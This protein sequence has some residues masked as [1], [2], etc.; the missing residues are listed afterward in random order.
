MKSIK[1]Q[2]AEASPWAKNF[3]RDYV[4]MCHD[5]NKMIGNGK[6]TINYPKS[7]NTIII[8]LEHAIWSGCNEVYAYTN[9]GKKW[10]VG[11]AFFDEIRK[12]KETNSLLGDVA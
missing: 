1:K 4:G 9:D 6:L 10:N 3:V 12:M 11:I 2:L 5:V 7:T 8:K